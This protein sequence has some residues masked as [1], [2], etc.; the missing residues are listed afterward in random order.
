MRTCTVSPALAAR[1]ESHHTEPVEA[2][3]GQGEALTLLL[4]RAVPLVP[5]QLSPEQQLSGTLL[6]SHA[7]DV[8]RARAQHAAIVERPKPTR[9]ACSSRTPRTSAAAGRSSSGTL[10]GG[11]VP[12]GSTA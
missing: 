8:A 9:T 11:D 3:A 4:G 2:V 10:D 7:T 1:L 6:G 12:R 5:Q